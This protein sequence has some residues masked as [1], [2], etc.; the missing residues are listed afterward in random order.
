MSILKLKDKWE[1]VLDEANNLSK[2]VAGDTGE[3]IKFHEDGTVESPGSKVTNETLVD[4]YA[5]SAELGI[6]A[7]TWSTAQ[8]DTVV[9]DELG[10]FD[11][12]NYAF[13]P[14]ETGWYFV[15]AQ[16]MINAGGSG[17]VI[18]ARISAEGN[19][20]IRA[21]DTTSVGDWHA[22][23]ITGIRELDSSITYKLQGRDDNNSFD[24]ED[25]HA[26]TYMQI[27]RAFR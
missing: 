10:E 22:I 26:H 1:W 24:I 25:G 6:S 27:R 2:F 3:E 20:L 11:V 23:N 7:D 13:S 21:N 5:S 19:N 16:V 12:D 8:L 18:R 15:S 4:V 14:T 17:D 9:E